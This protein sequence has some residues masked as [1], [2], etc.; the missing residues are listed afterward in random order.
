MIIAFGTTIIML[1]V[2]VTDAAQLWVYQ[3]GLHSLADGA[4][5][6]AA[7]ALDKTKIYQSGVGNEIELSQELAQ[8]SVNDYISIA[9]SDNAAS[10]EGIQ[11]AAAVNGAGTQV[12]VTCN[13]N[14]KLPIIG[15]VTNG[16]TEV[17]VES[18]ATAQTFATN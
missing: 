11:C 2:V 18:D 15:F 3:R 4:S 10:S 8:Q 5:L 1:L 12:T 13:G 9:K 17:P 14:A 7:N 16:R 6:E